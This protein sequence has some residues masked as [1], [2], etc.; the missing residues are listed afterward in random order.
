MALGRAG[1]ARMEPRPQPTPRLRRRL[2]AANLP[3]L[4]TGTYVD[5]LPGA[6][7]VLESTA[8]PGPAVLVTA[9]A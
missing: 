4:W 7:E 9:G 5:A 3:A 2:V 8:S 1:A 6:A